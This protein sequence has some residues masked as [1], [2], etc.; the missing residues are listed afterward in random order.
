MNL[1]KAQ[2]LKESVTRFSQCRLQTLLKRQRCKVSVEDLSQH[3][4]F[5]FWYILFVQP[6]VNR[7]GV[8]CTM[9]V[10]GEHVDVIAPTPLVTHR[11][12]VWSLH[13]DMVVV[14]GAQH[15]GCDSAMSLVQLIFICQGWLHYVKHNIFQADKKIAGLYD[16]R[17]LLSRP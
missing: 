17:K 14:V 7:A 3:P 2:R 9:Y 13:T 6:Q 12:L 11:Q 8:K 16:C 15:R 5:M 4:L 10:W 1:V